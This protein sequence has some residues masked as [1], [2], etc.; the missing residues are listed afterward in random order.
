[1]AWA[2]PILLAGRPVAAVGFDLDFTLWDQNAFIRSFFAAVAGDLGRRLGLGRPQ[3][4]EA[5]EG[6]LERLT[7]A[8]PRLFD[9]ALHRLGAWDPR[10]VAE[11]VVRY[12]RHRAPA[13]PYP[14]AVA[15]LERCRRAGLRLFLV[16][17]GKPDTQR[18]KV[19]ALGLGPW[20][21]VLVFTGDLPPEQSK[22]SPT[23]FQIA[24][25]RLG[26]APE[27]CLFVGDHPACDVPGARS[28]GMATLGVRTG[29]FAALAA[30]SGEAA[31]GG[32]A[33]D[34]WI[35]AVGE[36]AGLLE[37]AGLAAGGRP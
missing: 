13:E 31:G 27:R 2:E 9:Q 32:S 23:P 36:L 6:A 22:P 12:R 16:T 35:D 30:N 17:D 11:L 21:D 5:C 10:L 37:S 7:L 33:P 4:L 20:F 8:H 14:G 29:P 18:Y 3:V 1:M 19:A 28:L 15:A 26:V 24:C 34:A 25:G